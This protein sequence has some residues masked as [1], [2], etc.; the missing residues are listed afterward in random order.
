L[1]V[2]LAAPLAEPEAGVAAFGALAVALAGLAL[3]L[4]GLTPASHPH[5]RLGAGNV[6]TLLRGAGVAAM[7]GVALAGV[8][9][10]DWALVAL[11]AG[12]VALDGIDG[13][14]ARASGTQSDFGARL[15]VETDVAL[16]AVLA[17][18]AWQAGQAGVWF[19]LLPLFRPAWLL[20][21]RLAPWIAAPLP[22]RARR[23]WVAGAQYAGQVALL[24]PALAPAQ[25]AVLAAGI[26]A[27]V[28]WSFA[29][30]LRWLAQNRG[31]AR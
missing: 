13:R 16:A 7:A 10:P 19:L 4:H 8:A 17:V 23:K 25:A 11:A 1:S 27:V 9:G 2:A 3:A 6:L 18:L 28:A 29:L 30:D 20:A 14:A 22:P 5:D 15:D 31:A 21:G 12:L 26:V 24:A